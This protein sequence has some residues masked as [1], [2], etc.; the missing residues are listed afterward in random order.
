[1]SYRGGL[2]AHVTESEPPL[3]LVYV[4]SLRRARLP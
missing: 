1:M 4:A 3:Q 2:Q